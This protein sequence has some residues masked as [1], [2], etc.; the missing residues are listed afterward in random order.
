[1][2]STD[3]VSQKI[4]HKKQY[5]MARKILDS[6]KANPHSLIIIIQ[7]FHN[8]LWLDTLEPSMGAH[9]LL[10]KFLLLF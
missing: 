3:R 7:A 8:H 2:L 5:E 1:M 4:M 9:S 6:N 10:D